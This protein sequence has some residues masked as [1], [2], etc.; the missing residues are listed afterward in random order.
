[1]SSS[2]DL[3]AR[4]QRIAPL[5]DLLDA[6]FEWGRQRVVRG[7]MFHG[8]SGLILDAGVGT[9]RNFPFYPN[10][11]EVAGIDLSPAMLKR[12][13]PRRVRS[14]APVEL[15]V[16][17]VTRLDFPDRS[18]DAVVASFLFCV[19]SE[20][21]QLPALSELGRV[22]RP[23]G[24]IRLLD[25]VRPRQ[26]FRRFVTRLWDPWIRRAF[27]A[28]FDRAPE[29]YL[30]EAGLRLV[31]ARFVAADLIRLLEAGHANDET[32][33]TLSASLEKSCPTFT[34]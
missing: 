27:G 1:M 23:A 20:E 12:A 34:I 28:S 29:R 7:E 31:D 22:L 11:S 9:G 32:E 18:F 14:S 8:L 15:R 26:P 5:Y 25:Y 3:L 10:A 21:Q 4:Y 2:L 16:M 13:G 24:I 17:D 19:L 6:P 30:S 33:K